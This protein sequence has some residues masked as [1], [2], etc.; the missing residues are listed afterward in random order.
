MN[1]IQPIDLYIVGGFLGAGKTTLLKRLIRHFSGRKIGVIVNEFGSIGI[2]GAMLEKDKIQ[3]IEI[4]NGSIF[5]ACIKD[6]F[7][8]TLKGFSEQPIDILLIENS[9]M[10]DPTSMANVL[11]D[12]SPYL[13]RQYHYR[14]HLC[15]IDSVSFL[16]VY[17]V[18][19]PVE[20]Q[21]TSADLLIVNKIDLVSEKEREAVIEAVRQLN[22]HAPLIETKEAKLP[23]G[24]IDLVTEAQAIDGESGNTPYNRPLTASLE[25]DG[26]V[27]KEGIARFV[28]L[29][30][31]SLYRLKGLVETTDGII[32]VSYASKSLVLETIEKPLPGRSVFVLIG[33][34]EKISEG[35][36]RAYWTETLDVPVRLSC[37]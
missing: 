3:L 26:A 34:E 12:L 1:K 28:G 9:G 33:P 37:R 23:P 6:G 10:A 27:S 36:I 24:L 17:D 11:K 4:N 30:G 15:L 35:K 25:W 22:D 7:V 32:S 14:G 2:D 16:D 20:N 13:A 19:T 18:L 21:V 8:R 29:I 5:C 31:P